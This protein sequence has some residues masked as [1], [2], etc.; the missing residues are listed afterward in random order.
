MSSS[1]SVAKSGTGTLVLTGSTPQMND[2][3]D[4]YINQGAI[5][6]RIDGTTADAQAALAAFDGTILQALS[7]TETALSNYAQSL[8]RRWSLAAARDHAEN[9]ARIVRAQAR[10]GR[11]DSLALLDAE[12][13]ELQAEDAVAD[14][15]AGVFTSVIAVY[16]ALG[17]IPAS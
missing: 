2:V 10:E 14:A 5:R 16:K 13:T 4:V 3:L 1:G 12:R 8:D 9:V 11:A 15:E 6:A 7:E 17:G